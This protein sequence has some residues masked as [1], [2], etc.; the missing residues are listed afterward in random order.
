MH[1]FV[2]FLSLVSQYDAHSVLLS[3]MLDM[4]LGFLNVVGRIC[5]KMKMFFWK[6]PLISNVLPRIIS[7]YGML[8]PVS[9][10]TMLSG[11]CPLVTFE[12]RMLFFP[13]NL[14]CSEKLLLFKL[15]IVDW[16]HI[17]IYIYT[18]TVALCDFC[19][20]VPDPLHLR[21]CCK[22]AGKR[23]QRKRNCYLLLLPRKAYLCLLP[24]CLIALFRTLNGEFSQAPMLK[25]MH[26]SCIFWQFEA[27]IHCLLIT[28][29]W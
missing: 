13:P 2:L 22:S 17:Y 16:W 28:S 27:F 11:C 14:K 10:Y 7:V 8:R 18:Y 21:F 9:I 24:K 19:S 12:A 1:F 6:V 23:L 29:C 3:I 26:D 25:M 5:S 4:K 15:E 20:S